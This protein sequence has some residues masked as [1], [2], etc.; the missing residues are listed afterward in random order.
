MSRKGWMIR[1]GEGGR[2]FDDFKKGYIA[3][4][5]NKLGDISELTTRDQLSE[6]Y[7]HAYPQAKKG[8][9]PNQ[10]SMIHKFR[11]VIARGDYAI[12]YDPTSRTYLVGEVTGDYQFSP[13]TVGDYPQIRKVNWIREV[14]R[15]QLTNSTRSSL[16]STLTL[17]ALKKSVLDELTSVANEQA[18]PTHSVEDDDDSEIL[19]TSRQ[20]TINQSKELIKDK[21]MSLDPDDM[22]HMVA[23]VLRG[24][25]FRTRVSP[26]GARPRS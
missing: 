1:A 9:L 21:I 4:G 18:K 22:E 19:Q 7:K 25:G 20:D 11:N 17:F 24:M 13:E 2:L 15:D 16:G 5:W 3:V 23:A 6:A 8:T 14:S 26:K 12:T 10:I